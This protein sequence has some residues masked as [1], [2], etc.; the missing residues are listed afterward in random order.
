[1]SKRIFLC[2]L[3]MSLGIAHAD[4]KKE[5]PGLVVDYYCHHEEYPHLWQA[6][7]TMTLK[8]DK[9]VIN[10]KL[11]LQDVDAGQREPFL[12]NCLLPV[13]REHVRPTLDEAIHLV[14]KEA[15]RQTKIEQEIANG[16]G[17]LGPQAD[18]H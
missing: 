16:G 2:A 1:M 9:V 15:D 18:L 6:L 8:N 4:L 12:D 14:I 7:R 5:A 11:A 3:M 13:L 17:S 10:A